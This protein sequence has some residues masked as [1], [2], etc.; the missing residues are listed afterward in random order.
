[1]KYLIVRENWPIVQ[2]KVICP[3]RPND[4]CGWFNDCTLGGGGSKGRVCTPLIHN[5]MC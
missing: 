4:P 2:P 1:M 3:W 5:A